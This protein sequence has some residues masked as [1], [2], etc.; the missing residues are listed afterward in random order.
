MRSFPLTPALSPRER[1]HHPLRVGEFGT[2]GFVETRDAVL[3]LPE[4][5]GRGEGESSIC[6]TE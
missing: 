5:E 2:L 3:P 4:G 1:E 6:P